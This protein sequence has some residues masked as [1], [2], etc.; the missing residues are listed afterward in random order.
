MVVTKKGLPEEKSLK[1]KGKREVTDSVLE[2][3]P[4]EG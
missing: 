3:V 4:W 2:T 1:K